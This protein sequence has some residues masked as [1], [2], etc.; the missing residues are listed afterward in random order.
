MYYQNIGTLLVLGIVPLIL[1]AYWNYNIYKYRKPPPDLT[2]R[3]HSLENRE[4]KNS[5]VTKVLVGIV[6]FFVF[7]HALRIFLNAYNA[8]T[9]NHGTLK[10]VICMLLEK[11]LYPIWIS[12]LIEFKDLMLVINSSMNMVIYCCAV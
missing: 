2:G 1:L 10:S 8:S 6:A 4:D 3:T 7:C 5:D 11:D 9:L 12:I